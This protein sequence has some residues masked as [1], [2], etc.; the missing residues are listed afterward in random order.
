MIISQM[1]TD[2]ENIAIDNTE[3]VACDLSV[4]NLHLTFGHLKGQG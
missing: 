2:G 3:K 1:V 4:G